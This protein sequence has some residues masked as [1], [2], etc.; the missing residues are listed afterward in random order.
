M[1]Q[2]PNSINSIAYI[3]HRCSLVKTFQFGGENF[4]LITCVYLAFMQAESFNTHYK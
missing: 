4:I 1:Q 2:K 3:Y